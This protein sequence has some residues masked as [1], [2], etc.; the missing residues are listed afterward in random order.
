MC[1]EWSLYSSERCAVYSFTGMGDNRLE[2]G[3]QKPNVHVE[4][5]VKSSRWVTESIVSFRNMNYRA[6]NDSNKVTNGHVCLDTTLKW[7][8]NESYKILT[9]T[10]T[11]VITGVCLEGW[12]L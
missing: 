3:N 8:L 10:E 2:V 11:R 7:V 1:F 9:Q 12:E 4:V 6:C 5:L